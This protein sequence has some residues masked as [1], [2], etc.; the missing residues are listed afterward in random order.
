[1]SFSKVNTQLAL[2]NKPEEGY[3]FVRHENVLEVSKLSKDQEADFELKRFV[4]PSRERDKVLAL[5]DEHNLNAFSLFGSEES[6]M[7]TIAI[8]KLHL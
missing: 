8:R 6:L 5:L 7:Q 3:F 4:I 2:F 1:M